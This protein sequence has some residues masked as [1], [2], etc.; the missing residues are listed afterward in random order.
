MNPAT[1]ASRRFTIT[2]GMA[3][4]LSALVWVVLATTIGRGLAAGQ[5]SNGRTAKAIS[6][7]PDEPTRTVDEMRTLVGELEAQA[8]G[9]RGQ[10]QKTEASLR[11]ARS[12]LSNLERSQ[13][14]PE[15]IRNQPLAK[16]PV[17][18]ND[19]MRDETLS[20]Q[21]LAEKT[22]WSWPVE[23]ST[24]EACARQFGG[25][26]EVE[27]T[28]PKEPSMPPMI[29]VS[30]DENDIVA[31]RA[32]PAS[33]FVRRGDVLFYADFS[34]NSSGCSIVAYHLQQGELWKT[35]LWG[36]VLL[37]Q[38]MYSNRVNLKLD[39]DHLI[40]YGDESAGKYIELVDV[41][42]GRIVGR[43]GGAGE[44]FKQDRPGRKS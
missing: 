20:R 28:R 7:A 10:L 27:I 43:K 34:P 22:E 42:T 44:R 37:G 2:P 3:A 39:G 23:T 40:V 29:Q 38:S 1:G 4:G 19:P 41:R 11:R 30:R 18:P 13:T 15:S 12:V 26:Y 9:E 17:N 8:N 6:H 16:R 5:P 33:V 14:A 25:G 21:H 24:P 32:H 31:W 35:P 36:I